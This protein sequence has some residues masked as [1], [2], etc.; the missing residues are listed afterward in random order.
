[1]TGLGR[2]KE[3]SLFFRISELII[4][5]LLSGGALVGVGKLSELG[6]VVLGLD[7]RKPRVLWNNTLCSATECG[8][9]KAQFN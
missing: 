9:T 6:E 4:V 8:A 1:M 2:R 3:E 7:Q 5:F